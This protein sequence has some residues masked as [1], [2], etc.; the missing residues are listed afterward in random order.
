MPRRRAASTSGNTRPLSSRMPFGAGAYMW[1][2][3][4]PRLS[5]GRIARS[6][7][8]DWPMWIITGRS[9]GAAASCARQAHVGATQIVQFAAR[10]NACSRD[11]DQEAAQVRPRLHVGGALVDA[12]RSERACIDVAGYAIQ[13]AERGTFLG[14]SGVG[15][16]V[17]EA[18]RH[19]LAA[20]VDRF[21]GV[22]RD[23]FLDSGD[24]PAG[25]RHVADR[26]DS[27]RRID[28]ASALDDQIIGR[29]QHV[30]NAG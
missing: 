27:E 13:Q 1:V 7:E 2:T 8:Y 14:A 10:G 12:V 3:M 20:G 16:D 21:G 11:V 28:D 23:I 29:R 4:S 30:R 22:S 5:S 9:K 17:E 24:A 6:G 19:D 26:V 15:M 18:R 25:N